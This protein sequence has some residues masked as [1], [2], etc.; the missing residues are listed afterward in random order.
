SENELRAVDNDGTFQCLHAFMVG[1]STCK[2]NR[3]KNKDPASRRW[4]FKIGT[5]C[6]F[7]RVLTDK[8]LLSIEHKCIDATPLLRKLYRT[9]RSSLSTDIR[10]MSGLKNIP[11]RLTCSSI[12]SVPTASVRR[13]AGSISDVQTDPA[14]VDLRIML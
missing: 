9:D 11:I 4:T 12:R 14:S 1:Q 3:V 13:D 7:G 5:F 6:V 2:S 8:E 10:R